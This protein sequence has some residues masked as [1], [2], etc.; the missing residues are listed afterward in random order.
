LIS[1]ASALLF[2]CLAGCQ[3]QSAPAPAAKP[4][5]GTKIVVAAPAGRG[6]A[7]NWKILL[8]EWSEQTGASVEVREYGEQS[9]AP[10]LKP[11]LEPSGGSTALAD[12]DLLIFSPVEFG[13]LAADNRLATITND[14]P[15]LLER[16][17]WTDVF[18]G[19][20][21]RA[22]SLQKQPAVVPLSSPVLACYYRQDLLDKAGL[23]P[24]A[25]WSDYQKLLDTLEKWAPGMNAVEPWSEDFRATMFLSRAVGWVKHPENFSVFF[26][27]AS[28][29]PLIDSPG[30]VRGLEAAQTALA[31]LPAEVKN[32]SPADCRREFFAGKAAL[33]VTFETGTL[34]P[35][36]PAASVKRPEGMRVGIARLPGVREIYNRSTKSWNSLPA[37]EINRVALTGFAG[38]Y[39][40]VAATST[41]DEIQAAW[42]LLATLSVD[43][44]DAAFGEVPR[45]PTRKSQ[46]SHPES[47]TGPE[48]V[49][50]EQVAY[51]DA[52]D[53]ALED[54][55]LVAEFPVAGRDQFRKALSDGLGKAMSAP[56]DPQA[57]LKA[58]A[59]E[60]RA[61]AKQIGPD[62]ILNSYRRVL[63]LGPRREMK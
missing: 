38:L 17:R 57:A 30:F 25:T 54:E 47:W 6:F 56:G 29:E 26:D 49:G 15:A 19:L 52:V 13:E 62:R 40:G 44:F 61:I 60:W 10:L 39:G 41:P 48:L 53:A 5:A 42:S 2:C 43:R 22:A 23:S 51:V 16:I 7:A 34:G 9:Q 24:P 11:L 32:Y 21:E 36:V 20:R 3:N 8:D 37:E 1:L 31:R 33:A 59:D 28:G 18:Q 4:F 12:A 50:D 27:I 55:R 45:A 46:T 58:V 14:Q 35:D 63:G